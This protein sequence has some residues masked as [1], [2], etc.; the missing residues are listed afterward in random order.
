MGSDLSTAARGTAI[1]RVRGLGSAHSGAHHWLLMRFTAAGNLIGVSYLLITLLML[2]DLTYATV[3]DWASQPL[4]ATALALLVISTFWH[5]RLGVQV[6]VEDYV[7]AAGLKFA[8]LT[9]LNLAF[10]AGAAFGL[11]AIAKIAFGGA[12]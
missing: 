2:P 11:V 7:H 1:G 4:A 5:A 12:A 8:A 6:V 10:F 3:L 9:A